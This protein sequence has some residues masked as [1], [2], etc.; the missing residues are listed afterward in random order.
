MRGQGYLS[1]GPADRA[2]G[3][4]HAALQAREATLWIT[5]RAEASLPD[6]GEVLRVT[7]TR[8][9]LGTMDPRRAKDLRAAVAAF[10]DR[11]GPG[12]IVIDCLETLVAH[13][14]AERV[15]RALEDLHEEIATRGAVLA[16]FADP[17]TTSPQLVAMLEREFEAL[18]RRADP[19]ADEA[20]LLA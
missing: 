2:H 11:R 4:A 10:L 5:Q 20:P 12:T 1:L 13:S 9:P 16:V 3:F 18:P 17:E 6:A 14:D 15:V 7:T 19:R 8:A